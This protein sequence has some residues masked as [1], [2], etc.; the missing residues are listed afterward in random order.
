M[1][2]DPD[3]TKVGLFILAAIAIAAVAIVVLGGGALVGKPIL[4]ETYF[5]QSVQGL[6]TGAPIKFRGVRIGKTEEV[7]LL[8][9]EY[10]TEKNYV[11]V[12]A[13]I[14]R[15][16]FK[17][18]AGAVG[19]AYVVREIEKGLRIRVGYQ[20]LTGT[21]HLEMDYSDPG[22]SPPLEIDWKPKYTYIPSTP[23]TITR[24]GVAIDK[25]MRNLEKINVEEMLQHVERSMKSLSAIL[26]ESNIGSIGE[27]AQRLLT[28][29][30]ETNRT[31]NQILVGP[32]IKGILT[33]TAATFAV[34]KRLAENSEKP[35]N[36]I[37]VTLGDASQSIND[38][39]K[40]LDSQADGLPAALA[41]LRKILR[42]LDGLIATQQQDV[43]EVIENIRLFSENMREFSENIKRSPSQ[44]LRGKP[45]PP[46]KPARKP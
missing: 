41:E 32:K 17:R 15:E 44:L 14:A 1:S 12:R 23:S 34:T 4:V 36:Q 29:V 18:K 38:I 31:L 30:R 33:D 13:S 37:L 6:D 8:A 28:E 45:P 39:T 24:I 26:S 3:Y 42:R 22:L 25:I 46:S 40:K 43:E 27:Q 20:G 7:A 21:A 16:A 2:R 10:A 11:L 9:K 5:E 35:L 19:K